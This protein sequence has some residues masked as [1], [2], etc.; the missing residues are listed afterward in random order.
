MIKGLSTGKGDDFGYTKLK[1][2]PNFLFVT[3]S[4]SLRVHKML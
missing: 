4:R 1:V 3:P 2:T